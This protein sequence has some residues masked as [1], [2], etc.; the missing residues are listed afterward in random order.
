VWV[1]LAALLITIG[2]MVVLLRLLSRLQSGT[3]I[4]TGQRTMQ[5]IERVSTGPRQG[6]V[7]LRVGERVLIVGVGEDHALLGEL[8]PV[9][10]DA[11]LQAGRRGVPRDVAPGWRGMLGRFGLLVG[12]VLLPIAA[13]AQVIT[14]PKPA[15]TAGV[16][17]SRPSVPRPVVKGP[18]APTVNVSVG[19]P[20]D[21]LKLSGAV[22]IVV[23]MGALTLLPAMFML[24]TGFTRILIVLS[25]LR[26]AIGTQTAPPT[27]L[28]VAIAVILTGVVMNPVMTQINDQALQPYLKGD[29]TQVGAYHAAVIPL[30]KF[31]LA[32]TRTRDLATFTAMTH[33]D[34]V[35]TIDDVPTMTVV[36]AFVTGELRTAFQMGFIIYIPFLIIDLIV[37]SVLMS[38]GMFMLP[39]IMV[40]LPFK[41]LLFV[42]ADGW[43]LVVQNLV[44]SFRV[45]T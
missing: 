20:G 30:R 2:V 38:M 37:A 29:S 1:P 7:L 6:V 41:L 43:M 16:A 26:S 34:T 8:A 19:S 11:A 18:V 40:S 4:L 21:E 44:A 22:G 12:L 39:P 10:R 15:P 28:L 45:A 35:A 36:A 25:F 9:E 5:V 23:F 33:S 14:A 42:L 13:R 24:M 3:P 17:A 32:N 31:M 27:T